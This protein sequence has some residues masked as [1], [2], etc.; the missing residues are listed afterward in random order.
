M[1]TKLRL[2]QIARGGPIEWLANSPDFSPLHFFTWGF[3]EPF[4]YSVQIKY[5]SHMKES[6]EQAI[7]SVSTE[8]LEK[9]WKNINFRIC[10]IIRVNGGHIE[11]FSI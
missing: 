7:A 10:N 1:D 4:V 5:P 11:H 3:V 9:A 2:G 6:I 8:T